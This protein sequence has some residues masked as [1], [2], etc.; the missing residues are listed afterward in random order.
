MITGKIYK[1]DEI[2]ETVTY[3][4]A[5][6]FE[7]IGLTSETLMEQVRF[8]RNQLLSQTD[9]WV[10]PDRIPTQEQLDYR[11]ALRDLPQNSS[12]ELDANGQLINVNWP[13]KPE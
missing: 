7:M 8:Q 10:L 13:E 4:N 1:S 9:W 3:E 12:P 6:Y 11:Q 2:V 5:D